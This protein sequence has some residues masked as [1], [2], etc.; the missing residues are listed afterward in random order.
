MNKMKK[1]LMNVFGDVV[2]GFSVAGIYDMV[3]K[4]GIHGL[5]VLFWGVVTTIVIHY[6]KKWLNATDRQNNN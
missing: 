1:I 5:F 2:T 6:L 4:E 3:I